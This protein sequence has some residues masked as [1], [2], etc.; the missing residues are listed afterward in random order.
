M[1]CTQVAPPYDEHP[2]RIG[3]DDLD[4]EDRLDADRDAERH[5]GEREGEA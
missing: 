5:G 4:D 2:S 3:D 1:P